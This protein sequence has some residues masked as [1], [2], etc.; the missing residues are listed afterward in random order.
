[1]IRPAAIA[2]AGMLAIFRLTG[3]FSGPLL[4]SERIH[5]VDGEPARVNNSGAGRQLTVVTWNIAH[6]SQFDAVVA[7]LRDRHA[8]VILLQEVDRFCRR[9]GYRDVARDLAHALEMNWVSAGEFQEIGEGR[10]DMPA[11]TGQAILSRYPIDGTDVIVFTRQS[12]LRWRMNP[13]QPRRGG[14]MALRARTGGIDVY[15]VHLESSGADAVRDAQL[16]DVLGRDAW[17]PH[18]AAIIGG[19]FNI[20]SGSV[21][22]LLAMAGGHGF[23]DALGPIGTRETSV[24][25]RHPIDW[26]LVRGLDAAGG[27]VARIAGI[28][29]HFPVVASLRP[30][31]LQ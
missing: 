11:I 26:I 30:A 23:V 1:M 27:Q 4:D 17:S 31:D 20:T 15:N 19:D 2:F 22:R 24:R 9:S 13:V 14:R 8:D 25:H 18:G 7:T 21:E 12:G 16:R 3:Y 29:D 28:S 5:A 10:G 6:G